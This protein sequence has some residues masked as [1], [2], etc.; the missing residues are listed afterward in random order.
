MDRGG[1]G[2]HWETVCL[3][4]IKIF[5]NCVNEFPMRKFLNITLQSS[6]TV[7]LFGK[8]NFYRMN[9]AYS[10]LY[11]W[12]IDLLRNSR[13]AEGRETYSAVIKLHF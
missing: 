12:R 7:L 5:Y 4:G 10:T 3:S 8:P 9:C 6:R 11:I 2:N 13:E 1:I